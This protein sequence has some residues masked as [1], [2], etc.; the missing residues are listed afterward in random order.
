MKYVIAAFL[1][2]LAGALPVAAGLTLMFR[3]PSEQYIKS[4]AVVLISSMGMCSGAQVRTPSGA[5]YVLT[6]GHCLDVI[7]N[8]A[9]IMDARGNKHKAEVVKEDP[10]ADLLLLRGLPNLPGLDVAGE[11]SKGQHVRAF[12]SAVSQGTI[13]DAYKIEGDLIQVAELRIPIS[14]DKACPVAPKFEPRVGIT[15]TG[16]L[17]WGCQARLLEMVTTLPVIPGNSGGAV[18][19]AEGRVVGVVS[20]T[21]RFGYITPLAD[22]Q[23]LLSAY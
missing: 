12:V 18:V 22:I 3:S 6:A 20:A 2:F 14:D 7:N 10:T 19:D 13:L 8:T 16:K 4:R 21:E 15:A 9:V 5:D 23:K 17:V 11:E 1:S